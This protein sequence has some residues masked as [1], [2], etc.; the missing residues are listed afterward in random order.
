[1]LFLYLGSVS[2]LI[3]WSRPRDDG[4]AVVSGYQVFVD[5]FR[6]GKILSQWSLETRLK[7]FFLTNQFN[8]CGVFLWLTSISK[9]WDVVK[10]L[11][12]RLTRFLGFLCHQLSVDCHVIAVQTLTDHPVGPSSLSNAVS[13]SGREFDPFV[14]F[15]YFDVH[16]RGERCVTFL[17]IEKLH[18]LATPWNTLFRGFWS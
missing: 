11:S 3:R 6:Y 5:G 10:D 9:F 13:L 8:L 1:M 12:V 7:V 2:T 18:Y 14:L 16:K 15:C 4:D 17:L